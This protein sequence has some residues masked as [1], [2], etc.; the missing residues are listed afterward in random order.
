VPAAPIWNIEQ[1]LE[2]PQAQARGLLQP[3]D[4][5]DLPQLRLPTQPVRFTGSA[6]SPAQRPPALG[7]HNQEILASLLG[8][9][10]RKLAELQALGVFGTPAA[11]H[12]MKEEK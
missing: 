12:G 3:V 1:A 10:A 8:C 4:H 5:P 2:S 7:E 6:P 11:A 9:G